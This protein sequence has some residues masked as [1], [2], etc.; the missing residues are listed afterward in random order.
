[1][2]EV[3]NKVDLLDPTTREAVLERAQGDGPAT[4]G[5]S[6]LTGEGIPALL[7]LIEDKLNRDRGRYQIALPAADGALVAWAYRSLEVLGRRDEDTEVVLTVRVPD[8]ALDHFRA[9][10]GGYIIE[11]AV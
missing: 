5:V 6:A 7:Q 11:P 9:K 4:V 1:M 3:L 8:K 10:A 2:V